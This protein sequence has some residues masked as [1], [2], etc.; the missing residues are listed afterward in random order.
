MARARTRATAF[1]AALSLAALAFGAACSAL[2]G[3]DQY[4]DISTCTGPLC[5][6]RCA[7]AGGTWNEY[8]ATCSCQCPGV[9]CPGTGW[10]P[11][12]G[13]VCCNNETTPGYHCVELP[14]AGPTCVEICTADSVACGST[15]CDPGLVCLSAQNS[16]CGV[17]FGAVAQSCAGEL[18][19]PVALPDGGTQSVDCCASAAIPAGTFGMGCAVSPEGGTSCEADEIPQHTVTLD[20]YAIDQLEVTVGRFRNFVASWSYGALPEGAGADPLKA[21]GG[22]QTAWNPQL[23]SSEAALEA[24][25]DC[26]PDATWTSALGPNDTRPITCVSW[27]VAFA[28]CVWDGGRLPTEAEW[29]YAATNGAR[30]D[31]YPWGERPPASDLA[32]Y[33]CTSDT[34][35]CSVPPSSPVPVGSA[36]GGIDDWGLFDL[37]GNVAEWVF[38]SYAPYQSGSSTEYNVIGIGTLPFQVE[39]GGSYVSPGVDLRA[40]ARAPRNP[41]VGYPDVGLRCARSQ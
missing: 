16:S 31:V 18:S 26:S 34:P 29:E 6:Q 33:D 32:V 1:G 2:T 22:W 13:S 20:A 40:A 11:M 7:Q 30:D 27:F 36:P 3:A 25:L 8:G 28:F 37:A 4:A 19:C 5:E 12:C 23:P 9:G 10:E 14:D 17:P 24:A 38:D 39:R 21:S 15:C 41:T 35:P